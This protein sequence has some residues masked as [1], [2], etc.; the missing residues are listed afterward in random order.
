MLPMLTLKGELVVLAM[1]GE[2]R[3]EH[4]W[5]CRRVGVRVLRWVGVS[6]HLTASAVS[7]LL[8]NACTCPLVTSM[9]LLALSCSQSE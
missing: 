6:S 3:W 7:D 5:L 2:L 1:R 8:V 4:G 9:W